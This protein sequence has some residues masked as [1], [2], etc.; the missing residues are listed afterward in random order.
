MKKKI[1]DIFDS[2]G[3]ERNEFEILVN[4][5]NEFMVVLIYLLKFDDYVRCIFS[6]CLE[7]VMEKVIDI[8]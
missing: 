2:G 6:S 5:V 4:L 7:I 8:E 3:V 1:I